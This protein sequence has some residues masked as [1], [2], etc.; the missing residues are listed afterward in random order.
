MGA[1]LNHSPFFFLRQGL[2]LHPELSWPVNMKDPLVST[3]PGPGL[4]V[5]MPYLT[6]YVGG[7]DLILDP[8]R[9]QSSR[10]EQSY[11]PIF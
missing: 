7:R 4:Q 10:E 3:S 6:P 9:R 5:C 8:R 2:S 1:F 11:F